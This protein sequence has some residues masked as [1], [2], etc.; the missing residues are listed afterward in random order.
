MSTQLDAASIARASLHDPAHFHIQHSQTLHRLAL[1]QHWNIP[2]GSKVLELG[3]GQGDC[4]T[5]L[6]SA[7]GEQGSVVAVDPADLDYGESFCSSPSA[8]STYL[9]WRITS[10]KARWVGGLL[11]SNNRLRTIS[12]PFPPRCTPAPAKARPL[13]R[14][15][16]PT[17]YG[18]SGRPPAFCP[19]S[20][21]SSSTASVSSLR[22]G[23]WWRRTPSAQPH[24]LAALTQAALECRKPSASSD[25]NVRTVLGPKRLTEL[26][27]AAGWQLESE[28]RVQ[29][30]EGVLDGQWEVAACLS[31]SFEKEVEEQVGD[32]RERAVVLASRDACEA[33]LEGV[34]GVGLS[35]SLSSSGPDRCPCFM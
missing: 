4:T 2:T 23:R 34:Q 17:A 32:E 21:P 30:G 1:L 33:S 9:S 11:G 3:C 19:P 14:R 12:P 8:T 20:A 28:S 5:V 27:L 29:C 7:V 18:T 24:V 10:R 25:S 22:S 31:S 26:A 35:V 6:A 13:T 15:C 16:S